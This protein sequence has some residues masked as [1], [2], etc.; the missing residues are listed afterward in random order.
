MPAPSAPVVTFTGR[1]TATQTGTPISGASIAIDGL[2]VVQADAGGSF[3]INAAVTSAHAIVSAPGFVTRD[4][5]IA[6]GHVIALDLI[7]IGAPFS[8]IF[9]GQL[10]RSTLESASPQPLAVLASAP[11]FYLQT[12]G[13]SGETVTH[14]VNGIRE[15]VPA[16]TGG[17]FAATTIEMGSGVRPERSGW[18]II[19]LVH[20]PDTGHCGRAMVGAASGHIWLN[21]ASTPTTNCADGNDPVARQILQH[22]VGHALGFWH[23]DV[24]GSLMSASRLAHTTVLTDAERYHAAIAYHRSAGN[25]EPD[26]DS[27]AIAPLSAHA[28][29]VIAD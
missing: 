9:Y 4:T 29:Y 5:H 6:S 12:D 21:T 24:P 25:V 26:Q 11:A 27:S 1:V 22:E 8:S 28:P 13:L 14:L 17:R 2:S 3:S 15:I 10:A 7:A 20:E 19:E 23:I 18:I 16:M